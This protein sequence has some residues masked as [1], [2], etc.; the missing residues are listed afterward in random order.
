MKKL[1]LIIAVV[2]GINSTKAQHKFFNWNQDEETLLSTWVDPTIY[3]K[4]AQI[5]L[6]IT[7]EL[8]WGYTSLS[9]SHYEA[10]KP[11]YTDIVTS[12]GINFHLF[13]TNNIKYYIGPRIGINF[14]ENNTYPLVGGV[15]GF[16]IKL[17]D[18]I[19]LGTRYFP[20]YRSDQDLQFYGGKTKEHIFIFKNPMIVENIALVLTIKL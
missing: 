7:K 11:S 3:D 4:G 15:I 9:V 5:G 10:L 17:I 19:R 8:E 1:L 13:N 6:E 16:D 14:R 2:L 20:D 18:D 12:G